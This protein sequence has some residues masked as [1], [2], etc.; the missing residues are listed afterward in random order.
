VTESKADFG[1]IPLPLARFRDDPHH[2]LERAE[3]ART[4]AEGM[5]T[6]QNKAIMLGVAETYELLTE[7]AEARRVGWTPR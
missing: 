3:E 4:L 1:A 5:D 2:W 6:S 7:N